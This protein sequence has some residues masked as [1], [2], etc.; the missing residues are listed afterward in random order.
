MPFWLRVP[1]VRRTDLR[2]ALLFGVLAAT[3][4]LTE[5]AV[6]RFPAALGIDTTQL[7]NLRAFVLEREVEAYEARPHTIYGRA[8][9]AGRINSE[10]FLAPEWTLE[11]TPGVPRIVCLGASTTEGGNTETITGAYPWRLQRALEQETGG[12]FEVF[13]CGVSG[14]TTAETTVAWFLQVKDYQPDLVILHHAVNDAEARIVPGY[15]ADYRH[16]RKSFDVPRFGRLEQALTR[17]SDLY[18]WLR[19]RG[20]IPT[21]SSLTTK[22]ARGPTGFQEGRFLPGSDHAFRRNILSI[23]LDARR[24]G[25]EVLLLTMPYSLDVVEERQTGLLPWIIGLREH[26][27]ILRE[28]AAEHGFLL[29][30]LEA[31]GLAQPQLMRAPVFHDLVHVQ[32]EGNEFKARAILELLQREW[33]PRR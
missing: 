23:A 9:E 12:R 3:L 27:Q 29:V 11:R 17:R 24:G 1:G 26:N 14:W 2:L 4:L 31:I 10:G 15:R 6:R 5:C 28:L 19:F 20:S 30:D 7:A 22:Y 16:F 18:T 13:N 25:A 8:P 21:L 33:L 32:P